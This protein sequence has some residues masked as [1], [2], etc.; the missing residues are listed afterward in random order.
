MAQYIYNESKYKKIKII[1][2][3]INYK[4]NPT[5]RGLFTSYLLSLS[6][7]ENAKRLKSLHGQLTQDVEFINQTMGKYYDRKHMDV[8]P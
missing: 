6:A 4:Y 8:S 5:I 2:F 7:T 3:F 1:P